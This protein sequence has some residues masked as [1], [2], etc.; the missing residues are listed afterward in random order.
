VTIRV[1]CKF[2]SPAKVIWISSNPCPLYPAC[3]MKKRKWNW[4]AFDMAAFFAETDRVARI[5]KGG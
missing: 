2:L 5:R 3:N 1:R 4:K